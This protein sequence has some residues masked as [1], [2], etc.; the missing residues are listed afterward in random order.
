MTASRTQT[1]SA[2]ADSRPRDGIIQNVCRAIVEPGGEG[3]LKLL[4]DVYYGA[5]RDALAVRASEGSVEQC[6]QLSL[7]RERQGRLSLT[8]MGYLVGNLAKE[9]CNWI[10]HGRHMPPPRPPDSFVRGKDV[11]DLGCSFGRWLWEFQT[12]ARSAVGL[13]RQWEYIELGRALAHREGIVVPDIKNGA[14]EDLDRHIAPSSVDLVFSRLV[15]NHVDIRKTLRKVRETLRAGGTIWLQV[16]SIAAPIRELTRGERRLR[17][18][19]FAGF[20]LLNS[21]VCV[22][23]GHQLALPVPGRMHELHRPAYPTVQWWKRALCAA[24]FDG[25]RRVDSAG[26]LAFYAVRSASKRT[27]SGLM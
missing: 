6:V 22:T 20:A 4:R 10:D 27:V 9:Y 25:F 13:E 15:F 1:T 8:R 2:E 14:A 21:A 19:A 23:T 7:L 18:R 11:L 16:E 26:T 12:A 5:D 3:L 24:G 17:S